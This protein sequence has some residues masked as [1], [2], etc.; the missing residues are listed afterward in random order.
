MYPPTPALD[1]FHARPR[2]FVLRP[3]HDYCQVKFKEVINKRWISNMRQPDNVPEPQSFEQ[4]IEPEPRVMASA[5]VFNGDSAPASEKS[6]DFQLS[7]APAPPSPPLHAADGTTT[8]ALD[9]RGRNAGGGSAVPREASAPRE[10][11]AAGVAASSSSWPPP[12]SAPFMSLA[13]PD[14][15]GGSKSESFPAGAGSR[16]AVETAAGAGASW[17]PPVPS[18]AP[19]AAPPAARP[20]YVVRCFST[21]QVRE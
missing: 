20:S 14:A 1:T 11:T 16:T 5:V 3:K 13:V 19:S 17:S 2:A 10:S 21:E 15:G 4:L 12:V 18:A 7:R 9:G 6:H 8:N